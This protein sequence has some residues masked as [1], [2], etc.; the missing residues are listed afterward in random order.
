M[1][2]TVSDSQPPLAPT[3]KKKPT[4]KFQRLIATTKALT[5]KKV[6]WTNKPKQKESVAEKQQDNQEGGNENHHK[7]NMK[8][9]RGK[10]K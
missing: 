3:S 5:S 1:V 6:M 8:E 4:T 2:Q 7:M 9:T 10:I